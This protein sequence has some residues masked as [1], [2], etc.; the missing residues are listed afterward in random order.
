MLQEGSCSSHCCCEDMAAAT[1][2]LEWVFALYFLSHIPIT[3]LIDLQILVPASTVYPQKLTEML[4][5]YMESFK[6]AMMLESPAWFRTF[7][8]CEAFLQLPFFPF[9]AYAFFKGGCKWIRT[10][11]II[12]STHVATTL[13]P[14]LA[15]ILFHDFSQSKQ[16]GPQAQQERLTLMSVYIPYL[17]IPLL[18]L[19]TMLFSPQ[20]NQVEK[21]KKK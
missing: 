7:V 20:Y 12:Y 4:K 17:L 16:Q 5:W 2:F 10:P 1:R 8:Y 15:H 13:L 3:L 9:A 19:F 14:V 11:A 21:K 6:D 18:I